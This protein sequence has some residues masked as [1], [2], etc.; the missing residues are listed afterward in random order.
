MLLG[1][2]FLHSSLGLEAFPADQALGLVLCVH[3]L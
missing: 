3:V 2:M 1:M